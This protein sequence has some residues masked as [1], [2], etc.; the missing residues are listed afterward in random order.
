MQVAEFVSA[1]VCVQVL[2]LKCLHLAVCVCDV[3]H[4]SVCGVDLS[5]SKIIL[6]PG[7]SAEMQV[8]RTTV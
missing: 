7:R 1:L 3:W 6:F 4:S 8:K 5:K 2:F